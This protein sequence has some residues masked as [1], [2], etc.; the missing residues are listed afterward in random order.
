MSLAIVKSQ[1]KEQIEEVEFAGKTRDIV[2][3]LAR[4]QGF[5]GDPARYGWVA[6]GIW[7]LRYHAHYPRLSQLDA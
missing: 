6:P 2:L 1:I 5:A 4:C 7:L 3:R